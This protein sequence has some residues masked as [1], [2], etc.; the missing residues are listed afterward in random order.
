MRLNYRP[1]RSGFTLL[2]MTVVLVILALLLGRFALPLAG[3]REARQW[4]QAETEMVGIRAALLG[5]AALHGHLPCPDS[6]GDG[7][8]STSCTAE[9]HLPFKTLGLAQGR[10]PWGQE[11]RYRVDRNFTNPAA[12][13]ALNTGFADDLQIF[14]LQNEKLT[15]EDERPVVIFFSLGANARP[16]GDN[17]LT[18]NRYQSAPPAPD[19]DDTLTWL[20]RPTLLNHLIAAGR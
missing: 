13:I 19:F 10:D 12:P 6:S 8:A 5:Y 3:Q 16:D 2:E 1:D 11:W 14:N 7:I 15:T 4:R 20:A 17:A 9:G 18:S